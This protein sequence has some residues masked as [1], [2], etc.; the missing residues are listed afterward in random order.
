MAKAK[1][2]VAGY[3]VIGQRLGNRL[4]RLMPAADTP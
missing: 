4:W 1:V 3:G 2:G